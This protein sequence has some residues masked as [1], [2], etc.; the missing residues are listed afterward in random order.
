[1]NAEEAF[2]IANAFNSR[3][4]REKIDDDIREAASK[5]LFHIDTEAMDSILASN[6]KEHYQR[7][8][9]VYSVSKNKDNSDTDRW[10]GTSQAYKLRISWGKL[11]KVEKTVDA[12]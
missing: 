1:M 11:K 10:G 8:P 6:L 3:S 2:A 12:D 9:L 5:G 7:Q 4:I